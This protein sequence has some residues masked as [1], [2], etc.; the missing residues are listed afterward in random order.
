MD[1]SQHREA[2]DI[3]VSVSTGRGEHENASLAGTTT[4]MPLDVKVAEW[5]ALSDSDA[6]WLASIL[7]PLLTQGKVQVQ[8]GDHHENV[9]MLSH[10]AFEYPEAEQLVESYLGGSGLAPAE[11]PGDGV[12]EA[13]AS[14]SQI[15]P[16]SEVT[17]ISRTH[18]ALLRAVTDGRV[19]T[20]GMLLKE[21]STLV[22]EPYGMGWTPIMIAT[23]NGHVDAVKALVTHQAQL[24][25]RTDD[26][27][28]ALMLAA[29]RGN[30]AIAQFL[31]S[32]GADASA[33]D[34]SLKSVLM[35][36]AQGGNVAIARMLLDRKASLNIQNSKGMSA[37]D[38]AV[39]E[40]HAEMIEL[41]QKPG[42]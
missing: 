8:L 40:G 32:K 31:L 19:A 1:N 9:E 21:E 3:F 4:S 16:P 20:L 27:L 2:R 6:G 41:L 42:V 13:P 12:V 38:Y 36:T 22:N 24:E 30:E 39:R 25:A 34:N 17:V 10:E 35:W 26:G 33:R 11:P 18:G 5:L 29:S 14:T 7:M 15:L 28:T 23:W 37:L